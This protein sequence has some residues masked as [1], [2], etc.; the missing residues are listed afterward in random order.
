M[1]PQRPLV[2]ESDEDQRRARPSADADLLV[3]Q[4]RRTAT[5]LGATRLRRPLARNRM[6]IHPG[7]PRSDVAGMLRCPGL[8]IPGHEGA[9]GR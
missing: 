6:T 3:P 7:L 9:N 1:Q 8:S 2:D 4:G 5:R